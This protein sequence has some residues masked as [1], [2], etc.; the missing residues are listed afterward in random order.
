MKSNTLFLIVISI[1]LL[2]TLYVSYTN[3]QQVEAL[4]QE[5][6]N[7]HAKIDSVL[8]ISRGLSPQQPIATETLPSPKGIG[9]A[10]LD[11]L[12]TLGDDDNAKKRIVVDTK[13]RIEDRYV[14]YDIEKPELKGDEVGNVVISILVNYS[15]DVNSAKLKSATGITNEEV[16]EACKK[17][18]LKTNFNYDPNHNYDKKQPGTITYI[19]SEK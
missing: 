4:K 15:G 12:M 7:L 13:Y 5:N 10:I 11:Y 18:A 16:I 17:A 19:F 14:R 2:G 9:S 6:A 8:E 1:L 3:T